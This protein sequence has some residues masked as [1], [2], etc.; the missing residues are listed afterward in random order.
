[1]ENEI[2]KEINIDLAVVASQWFKV[3]NYNKK[4]LGKRGTNAACPMGN[5]QQPGGQQP[6]WNNRTFRRGWVPRG[7]WQS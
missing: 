4:I 7:G 1:M 5:T 3:T 6:L 2:E